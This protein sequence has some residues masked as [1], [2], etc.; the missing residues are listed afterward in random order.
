[1]ATVRVKGFG[2]LKAA[3]RRDLAALHDE[4]L[5]AVH[6]T[7]AQGADVAIQTAPVAFGELVS[8]IHDI[9]RRDGATIRADAPHA[10]AVELGSRPHKPPI[11]PLKKWCELKGIPVNVAWAIQAKIAKQGTRP[12][13]FMGRT[14]PAVEALLAVN[15]RA[16]LAAFTPRV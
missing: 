15:I 1:M 11:W 14:V 3:L 6:E 8:S 16:K 10:A 7:A 5:E 12:T 4:V 9:P 2:G 13:W